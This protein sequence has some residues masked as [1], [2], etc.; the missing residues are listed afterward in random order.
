MR[1]FFPLFVCLVLG[2]TTLQS[3]GGAELSSANED[4][5]L[6]QHLD[7]AMSQMDRGPRSREYR[8][9]LTFLRAHAREAAV[10]V[11]ELLLERPGGFG[12]W[13]VTYLVGEF[14]DGSAIALLRLLIDEPLPEPQVIE[15]GS[16]AI[17]LSYTEELASRVQ[18]VMSTA[19]IASL[20]PEFREQAVAELVATA[21][22][23]PPLKSTA[24]FELQRLLGPEFQT[25]RTYFG[26]EDAKHFD[27]FV[28]PP[29]WQ[30][31]LVRRMQEHQRKED[32]RRET[33]K[34][35][36]RTEYE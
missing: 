7:A 12:K 11:S 9:S 22:Q 19:R 24:L 1:R 13:Q 18:A 14:G 29:E 2:A 27:P 34:P 3:S 8:E 20:R 15:D 31:L 25:L 32:E 23:V 28:P 30:A 35:L 26:P 10:E 4:G 17:D 21:Q 5:L 16:H 36:C 33:R 6:M